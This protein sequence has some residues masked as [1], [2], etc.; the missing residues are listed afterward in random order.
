MTRRR[1]DAE[2]VRRGLAG[3]EAE[4][5]AIVESG[6]VTVGGR[7]L[8]TPATLVAPG[9]S[10]AVR[11]ERRARGVS[12]GAGKLEAGL[13][14]FGIDP[15]GRNCLDAGASTG[16]FTD[17]LLRGGA[18]RVLAVDVG[19][20]QLAWE[21][22]TDPRVLVLE[23]TNVRDLR[24]EDLPFLPDLVVA[25]LSFVSLAGLVPTLVGLSAP[26]ADLVLLVKP[27]FEAPRDDV[28]PRGV[29]R[30]PEVWRR[31]I[32]GVAE[33]LRA[34]GARPLAVMASPLP[35]PAGNVEFLLHA[36]TRGLPEGPVDGIEAAIGDGEVLRG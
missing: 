9:E 23:R 27:Q 21:L 12:R 32:E 29:V 19:Y 13:A 16:G 5:R 28:G 22:R 4:A 15:A 35:G 7:P 14:R 36:T 8:N 24:P 3:S 26:D 18:T 20:G 33:A 11:S 31:A 6:L 25:D 1:L 17:R 34:C 30:E 10:V 2:L